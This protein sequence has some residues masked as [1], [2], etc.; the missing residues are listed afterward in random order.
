MLPTP[1]LII[2]VMAA[3]PLFLA[4]ALYEPLAGIGVLYAALLLLY[5]ALDAAFLP[6][7]GSVAIERRV[8]ERV[9]LAEP[10]RATPFLPSAMLAGRPVSSRMRSSTMGGCTARQILS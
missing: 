6:R 2:M 10:A 4:G 1:R 7:R 8:P 9:S 3:A 5:A